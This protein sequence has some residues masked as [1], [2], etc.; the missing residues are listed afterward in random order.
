MQPIIKKPTEPTYLT[1]AGFAACINIQKAASPT[2]I[3]A[4]SYKINSAKG[5]V[6]EVRDAAS[7][8]TLQYDGAGR[9]T[10]TDTT[11]AAGSHRLQYQYDSL[12]RMTQRTLSGTGIQS[13]E[14][15]SY[16]WDLAGRLLGHSTSIG[17][18]TGTAH[19]TNYQY[20][21]AGRLA[22]RKVQAGSQ[23]DLITQRYGYDAVERLAQIKYLKAE[24]NAGGMS[25][26]LIE[27]LD[28]RYDAG[29]RRTGKTSL[30]NT[31]MGASETPMTASYDAANRMSQ[32]SL[33]IAGQ[34]QTYALTYDTNGNL[35]QKQ[36]TAQ[37]SDKTSYTWDASN[38]LS[39]ISQTG[40]TQASSL[41]AS[42]TY[43][44][45]GRRIQSSIAQGTN[46]VCVRATHLE[47]KLSSLDSVHDE[48]HA[49]HGERSTRQSPN[50]AF[51]QSRVQDPGP[52]GVPSKRRLRRWRGPVARH[53]RQHR[54]PLAARAHPVC[55]GVSV[56][57]ERERVR[58]RHT[59]RT[60]AKTRPSRTARHPGR[61]AARQ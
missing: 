48:D 52:P 9:T 39:Q 60:G 11:T 35:T 2:D 4:S 27:Q 23:T 29:G 8:N 46:A 50:A 14:V 1:V 56:A 25:E 43:D 58:A 36:N 44:A 57:G 15:T 61:G 16:Q 38:R 28:Y 5:R 55:L 10:Q 19:T 6:T 7:V 17:G 3:C 45:M 32:I 12:D 31:G 33:S 30:N 40:A 26:Q 22:A 37:A 47:A 21:A 41:N 18:A 59:R 20:D 53:Q 34:T 13:P 42:F 24:G 49:H 51:L 54:A